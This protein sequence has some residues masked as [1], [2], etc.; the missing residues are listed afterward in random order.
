VSTRSRPS[1]NPAQTTVLGRAS[2]CARA[3]PVPGQT[4]CSAERGTLWRPRPGSCAE[5][6]RE[7]SRPAHASRFL[8]CG[9]ECDASTPYPA[10]RTGRSWAGVGG[11]LWQ[12]MGH[13]LSHR[14]AVPSTPPMSPAIVA[15]GIHRRRRW[16]ATARCSPQK[17]TGRAPETAAVIKYGRAVWQQGV[18]AERCACLGPDP[19]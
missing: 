18:G 4:L 16:L 9:R 7:F 14:S 19:V 8:G 10:G 11:G 6:A 1:F 3:R 12:G 15:T 17:T 2:T 13:S 5:G